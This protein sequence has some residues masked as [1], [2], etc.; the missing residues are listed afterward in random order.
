MVPIVTLFSGMLL[1][2]ALKLEFN[3]WPYASIAVGSLF[4]LSG[5]YFVLESIRTLLVIG[6][7]I[8]L[9]DLI[10]SDQSRVL[11]REGVYSMTRNPMLFGY[12]FALSGV[13]LLILSFSTTFIF[14]LLYTA[15]W[16]AW[17]NWR[18]EPALER[19]FGDEYR[20]YREETPFLVPR[21]FPR[22]C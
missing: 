15:L 8:P 10:P 20:R 18:E 3:M 17:I 11:V 12:L 2:E 13:G 21:M 14:P 9:G 1:D 22:K 5:G 7:G 19:R 16:T 4:L 6:G